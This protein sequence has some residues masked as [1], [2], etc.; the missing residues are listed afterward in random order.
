MKKKSFEDIIKRIKAIRYNPKLD[1]VIGIGKGGIVPAY[2][3]ARHLCL[4]LD[5]IWINFRNEDNIPSRKHPILIKKYVPKVKGKNILLVDDVLRTGNTLWEAKQH[6]LDAK[7]VKTFIFNGA[8]DY[9]LYNEECFSF[10][11]L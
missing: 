3:V 7:T 6:L 10:P 8:G 4:P 5:F 2:L 11:W 9:S 1:L